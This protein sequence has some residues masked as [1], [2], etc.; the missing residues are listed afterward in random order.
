VDFFEIHAG[1]K[2]TLEVP[3]HLAGIPDGV[4][5]A[6]GVL[7]HL[8]HQIKIR[9]L[10][11]DIPS[12]I[13]VDVTNLRVGASL[14]VSDLPAGTY[15]ILADPTATVC[16]VVAPRLEEEPVVAAAVTPEAPAEPELI[17]KLKEEE[18]EGEESEKE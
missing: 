9:V 2:V 12:H 15:E 16:T 10:P 8:L 14:H 4:R 7:D 17:R 3:V 6:A 11:T 5:N 13:E 1:E 18:E